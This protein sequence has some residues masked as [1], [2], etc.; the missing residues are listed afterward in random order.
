MKTRSHRRPLSMSLIV[1]AMLLGI[2]CSTATAQDAKA[3]AAGKTAVKQKRKTTA[4][5]AR[6]PNHFRTVVTEE[7]R[8]K[9]YAV[10]REYGPRLRELRSQLRA[11]SE[12]RNAKIDAILTPEQRKQ[13]ADLKEAAK[14]KRN[15]AKEEAAE[16]EPVKK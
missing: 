16:A 1:A 11:L 12:E 2:A 8:Q 3:P 7:Q 15:K 14:K 9:I 6:L 4:S 10:Q 13:I 5:D